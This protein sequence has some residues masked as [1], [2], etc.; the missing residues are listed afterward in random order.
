[1]GPGPAAAGVCRAA[2]GPVHPFPLG[3][4]HQCCAISF[5]VVIG[6]TLALQLGGAVA[7][8]R[9]MLRRFPRLFELV[10]KYE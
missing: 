8:Y 4:T 1:M 5:G 3:L 2:P 7:I 9:W 6:S 10:V